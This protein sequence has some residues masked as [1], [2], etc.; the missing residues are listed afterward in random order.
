MKDM[1]KGKVNSPQT[2]LIESIDSHS[3]DIKVLDASVFPEGPNLAVIGTDVQ[4]ETIKYTSIN[5]NILVGCTRGFQGTA[6]PWDKD[7]IISRNFTEYDLGSIQDNILE[8]DK[9]KVD[10]VEGK[11]LSS[12]DFTDKNK[13]KLDGIEEGANKVTKVSDLEN[14]KN[15]KTE[16]EVQQLINDATHLKKE[17]VENL[18]ET[19]QEDVIY[20]VNDKSEEGNVYT[21]YLWINNTWEKIGDT[22]IDLFNY[23]EKSE[24]PKNL[25]ELQEDE[26]H[27]LVTQEEKNKLINNFSGEDISNANIIYNAYNGDIIASNIKATLQDALDNINYYVADIYNNLYDELRNAMTSVTKNY[28]IK[29]EKGKANGYASLGVDGKVPS[30]QLPKIDALPEGG[31]TGQVLK[32]TSDGV[33]WQNDNNTTYSVATT[34]SNGL[35]SSSDKNIIDNLEKNFA[36]QKVTYEDFNNITTVGFYTAYSNINK[37]PVD[38]D[39][40]GLIV[41]NSTNLQG[42]YVQ[43]IAIPE[44]IDETSIWIRKKQSSSWGSWQNITAGGGVEE[45]KLLY[46]TSLSGSA[47]FY[48]TGRFVFADLSGYLDDIPNFPTVPE[49]FRPQTTVNGYFEVG[50]AK[51]GGISINSG[52]KFSYYNNETEERNIYFSTTIAYLSKI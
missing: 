6:K 35:M 9:N 22:K 23:A 4:A 15:Y 51:L 5:E 36:P 34:S 48:K 16:V 20:L 47:N 11:D 21:E 19:G 3:T 24:I 27:K 39:Y 43:Q 38:Y 40:F 46:D 28:Q 41:T 18:P 29:S 44:K 14:D 50:I 8:L 1:Y 17:V 33:A 26:T 49:K 37:P 13:K 10:K 32:K 2:Q 52:G 31:T 30:A 7:S 25:S 12:N 42:D 45:L